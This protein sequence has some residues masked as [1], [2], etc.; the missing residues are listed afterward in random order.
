MGI[1]NGA[2]ILDTNFLFIWL[3]QYGKAFPETPL[4]KYLRI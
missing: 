4:S 3:W 1:F 2:E